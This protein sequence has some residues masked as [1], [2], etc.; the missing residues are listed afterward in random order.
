[1]TYSLT[2]A[3]EFGMSPFAAFHD[4]RSRPIG[5]QAAAR[6]Q[7][8]GFR[9]HAI[10]RSNAYFAEELVDTSQLGIAGENYY[11]SERNPPYWRRIDGAIPELLVRK[12]VGEKLR[13]IDTCLR[14][15]GLE[16]F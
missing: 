12:T 11:W 16:L 5:D 10:E 15:V 14:A 8:T 6:S 3:V 7:R 4:L 2:D 1:M 13:R 9:G